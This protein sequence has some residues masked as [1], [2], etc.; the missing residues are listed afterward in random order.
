MSTPTT[1]E[2]LGTRFDV[3]SADG[4][5]IAVWTE[6][7]GPALVLVHGSSRTRPGV[8]RHVRWGRPR[9]RSCSIANRAAPARVELPILV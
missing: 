5:S 8:H 9:R 6:G 4:T 3:R 2:V 1:S 7:E